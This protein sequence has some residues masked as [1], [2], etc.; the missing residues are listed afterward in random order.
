VGAGVAFWTNARQDSFVRE[1]AE[2]RG[3]KTEKSFK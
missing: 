1:G 3:K 2:G